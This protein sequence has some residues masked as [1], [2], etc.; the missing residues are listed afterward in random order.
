MG[1]ARGR[2]HGHGCGCPGAGS[3]SRRRRAH[4]AV[5]CQAQF[6]AAVV[7]AFDCVPALAGLHSADR[8]TATQHRWE[9]C[10]PSPPRA[11]GTARGGDPV[12]LD[13]PL[14]PGRRGRHR[15]DQRPETL[16]PRPAPPGA[17]RPGPCRGCRCTAAHPTEPGNGGAG[18]GKREW[19]PSHPL[20]R[21][22]QYPHARGPSVDTSAMAAVPSSKA[23]ARAC[24]TRV[25]CP[26][27]TARRRTGHHLPGAKHLTRH[28]RTT[29]S[30]RTRPSTATTA[31]PATPTDWASF[32][33]QPRRPRPAHLLSPGEEWDLRACWGAPASTWPRRCPRDSAR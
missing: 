14:P 7:A 24:G 28:P 17:A 22:A 30:A 4:G 18:W 13:Q 11:G 5:L 25:H 1:W 10:R 2:G 27:S 15:G 33:N 19:S 26:H 21:S 3:R 29:W 23:P 9:W 16:Y 6:G 12:G 8:A 20:T 31:A 32:K